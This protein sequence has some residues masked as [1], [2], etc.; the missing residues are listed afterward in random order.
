[1]GVVYSESNNPQEALKKYE[2]AVKFNPSYVEALSNIGVIY[3]NACQ[4]EPA[5]EFYERALKANPNFTIAN[6]NIAIALTDMGTQVGTTHA[7]FDLVCCV[8]HLMVL[9]LLVTMNR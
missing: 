2:L 5:I 1:L 6:N 7:H 9:P 4:L 8:W 3:K